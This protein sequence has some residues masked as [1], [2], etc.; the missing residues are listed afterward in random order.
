M[1]R[2]PAIIIGG[3]PDSGKSTLTYHLSQTLRRRNVQHYVL[4]AA[5]DGEGDWTNEADQELVRTILSPKVWTT[6]FVEYVCRSL[7]HRHL[8]LIVDVGGR[9]MDW[10]EI[11]FDQCTHAI[12]LTPDESSQSSWQRLVN[13][14][15]LLLVADLRSKLTGDDHLISTAPALIGTISGLSRGASLM[16]P[17]FETLTDLVAHLFDYAPD[18]IRHH[19]LTTA[20]VETTI[21]LDRLAHLFQVPMDGHKTIWQPNHLADLLAYLPQEKPLGLY[22]R[23]PNWLYAAAALLSYPAEFSQF[24]VRL[25]WVTPPKLEPGVTLAAALQVSQQVHPN[26]MELTFSIPGAHLDYAEVEGSVI[27][28]A[29]TCQRLVLGGKMPHWLIVALALAYR[30]VPLLA[31]YQPQ[32]GR[33]VIHSSLPGFTPGD[34]LD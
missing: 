16:G 27:P 24:D 2:F 28:A 32:V 19:H 21:D 8:P 22:G 4:R 6:S 11:I 12:L 7:A 34:L 1:Q 20:P 17:V 26:Y 29:S 10:Q 5:P 31:V 14:H 25:G 18:Q 3:P 13:R 23:G 30:D 9:P 15:N 33:V